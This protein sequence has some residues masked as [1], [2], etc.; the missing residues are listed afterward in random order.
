MKRRNEVGGEPETGTKEKIKYNKGYSIEVEERMLVVVVV[1]A[2][3]VVRYAISK[4]MSL[5]GLVIGVAEQGD[6][7]FHMKNW[8][9]RLQGRQLKAS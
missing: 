4:M 7:Q 5:A 3:F 8:C 9:S 6:H 1:V 2:C